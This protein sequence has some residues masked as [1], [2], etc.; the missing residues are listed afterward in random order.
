VSDEL[1]DDVLIEL[2]RFTWAAIFL[3]DYANGVCS[4]IHYSNPREDRR[5]ISQKI[6]D[7]RRDLRSWKQDS[8][9]EV[10]DAWLGGAARALDRRNALLHSVPVV[11]MDSHGRPVGQALGE[12]PR[13]GKAYFE[14]HVTVEAVREVSDELRAARQG[15]REALLLAHEHHP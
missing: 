7:A 14:R 2:G 8:D 4:F 10:I 12:M 13:S 11:R 15:W 6:N 3:E 1:P 5:S 9:I